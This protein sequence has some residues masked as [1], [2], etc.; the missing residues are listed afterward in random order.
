M[1]GIT[2]V[3][4]LDK[5][6]ISEEKIVDFTNSLS[7]RGPDGQGIYIDNEAHLALGH[8]RLSILDLSE[9]GK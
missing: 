7:H 8:R 1:C 6:L 9:R 3:W 4:H 2:G 5:Q